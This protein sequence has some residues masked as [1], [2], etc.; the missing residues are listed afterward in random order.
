MGEDVLG[1]S[2]GAMEVCAP[3][4]DGIGVSVVGVEGFVPVGGGDVLWVQAER[5]SRSTNKG[6]YRLM[7]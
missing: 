2:V 6:R 5:K 3:C 4:G 7:I 1:M